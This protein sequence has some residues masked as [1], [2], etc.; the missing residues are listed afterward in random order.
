MKDSTFTVLLELPFPASAFHN[1]NY[2]SLSFIYVPLF[3]F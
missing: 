3:L 2:D 1:V